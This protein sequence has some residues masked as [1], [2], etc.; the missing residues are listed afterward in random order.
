MIRWLL[1]LLL[2][3]GFGVAPSEGTRPAVFATYESGRGVERV[4][5]GI[6]ADDR[7]R[8]R[9][10]I[11]AGHGG[12]GF[13]TRDNVGYILAQDGHGSVGRQEDLLALMAAGRNNVM[14]RV[15]IERLAR[16]RAEIV[17]AGT[18]TIAGVSGDVY[19]VTL[20]EGETRAPPFEIVISAAPRLAPVGRELR[21]FYESLRAPVVA[22]AGSVPQ[23]YLAVGEVLALGTPLRF[24]GMRLQS[25]ESRPL[26][27]EEAALPGPVL[28]REAFAALMA[29]E[30]GPDEQP[31]NEAYADRNE[32]VGVN[33][34]FEAVELANDAYPE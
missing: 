25:I 5:V 17:R 28:S 32:L 13:M 30:M 26:S 12:M 20:I 18:E 9:A 1:S 7:G 21:R 6:L 23:V 4:L 16:Q 22:V 3:A 10:V 31:V 19:R 27:D 11:G 24:G 15:M 29:G 34:S 33:G 8:V 14:N 2:T